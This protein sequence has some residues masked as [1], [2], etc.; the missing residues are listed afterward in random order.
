MSICEVSGSEVG[1]E[2]C[3]DFVDEKEIAVAE[4]NGCKREF[5]VL[6]KSRK[7]LD[8]FA[9]NRHQG[10]SLKTRTIIHKPFAS[11]IIP[12]M[13]AG[14]KVELEWKITWG[15]EEDPSWSGGVSAEAHDDNGNYAKIEVKKDSDGQASAA[16]YAGHN[17]ES[18]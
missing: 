9:D 7:Y 8:V 4:L 11:A 13:G 6:R 16:V 1:C 14:G 17:E 12:P 18:E 15:G 3:A 5:T 2:E 10:L